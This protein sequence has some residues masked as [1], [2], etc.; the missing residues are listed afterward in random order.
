MAL[1]KERRMGIYKHVHTELEILYFIIFFYVLID[2]N[3]TEHYL[4]K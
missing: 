3:T 2:V 4:N 1:L